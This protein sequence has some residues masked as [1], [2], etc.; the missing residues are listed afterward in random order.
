MDRKGA[1][2]LRQVKFT[3]RYIHMDVRRLIAAV[4][5][6]STSNTTLKFLFSIKPTEYLAL[7]FKFPFRFPTVNSE[8]S[9]LVL[10][11]ILI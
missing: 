2:Y 8:T 6:F 10:L 3:R 7:L 5:D 1:L 9:F 11:C 4:V